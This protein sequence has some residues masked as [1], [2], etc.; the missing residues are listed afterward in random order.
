MGAENYTLGKGILYFDRYNPDTKTY[1]GWRDL[2]NAPS[3]SFTVNI[4]KLEHF[5][6][7]GGL[8]VKDKEIISQLTPSCSFTLDEITAENF[9]I[10]GLAKV[11]DL[12]QTAQTDVEDTITVDQVKKN[13]KLFLSKHHVVYET[14]GASPKRPKVYIGSSTGTPLVEGVDWIMAVEDAKAGQ[15]TIVDTSTD[16][17]AALNGTENFTVVYDCEA[18]T[19]K[20][21]QLFT[22]TQILGR[23]RFVSDNPTGTQ[24]TFLAKNVSLT[25]SGDTAFIGD[26]WSTL[27][28]SAECL[29]STDPADVGSPYIDI[30]ME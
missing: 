18:S 24:C 30:T 19:M 11:V 22:E 21:I 2:G 27:S 13:E 20:K 14:T 25:P 7:R 8:R 12:T 16:V 9:G 5:S 3:F 28:F 29:K 23:L 15:I 4:E 26:D 1:S 6:S 10:L 17:A